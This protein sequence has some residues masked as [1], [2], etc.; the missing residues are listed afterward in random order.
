MSEGDDLYRA[1]LDSPEDDAPRL[2]YADWLDE[3]G[4]PER[5]EFIRVQCA[6]ARIPEGTGRWRSLNQQAQ[7]LERQWRVVW[8]APAQERVLEARLARGFVDAVRLTVEQF[9]F[10]AEALVRLEPVRVWEFAAT[11]MLLNRMSF[12]RLAADPALSVVRAL[13]TGKFVPDELVQSLAQSHYLTGLRTLV[14]PNRSPSPESI[15]SLLDAARRLDQLEM[16]DVHGPAFR[17]LWRRGAPIRL[18]RLSMVNSRVADQ[19]VRS[20]AESAALV[21]VE[22]LRLDGNEISVRGADAVASTDHLTN[23]QELSLAGNPIGDDGALAIARSPALRQ[24][25]VLNLSDCQIDGAGAQ[26]LADS[27]YLDRLECLCL[28]DNRISVEVERELSTRFGPNVCSFSW[29][30]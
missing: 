9:A 6:M 5:A 8:T 4:Q 10:A 20:L 7:A 17:E 28:D 25:R 12:E 30:P 29:G 18:R 23:L 14:V 27:P 19:T 11:S 26:S 3:H 22:S 15:I 21:L 24:L 2:I 13:N 16:Q 1:I